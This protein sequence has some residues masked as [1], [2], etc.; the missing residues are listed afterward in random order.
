MYDCVP[1]NGGG[2]FEGVCASDNATAHLSDPSPTASRFANC[3]FPALKQVELR[4]LHYSVL[5]LRF[6]PTNRF[7]AVWER[8]PVN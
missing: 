6:S 3:S 2:F 5:L 1:E 4:G 7:P 8:Y